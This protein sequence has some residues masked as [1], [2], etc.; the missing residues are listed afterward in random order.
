M[1]GATG[2]VARAAGQERSKPL[3]T[4][5]EAYLREQR[6]RLSPKSDLAKAI[7][8]MLVRWTSFGWAR[9]REAAL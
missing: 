5:L 7:R 2:A 9:G 4:A 3:V 6:E 8:Y 1:R